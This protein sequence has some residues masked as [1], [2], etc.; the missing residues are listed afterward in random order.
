MAEMK[1]TSSSV[2]VEKQEPTFELSGKLAA[3]TNRYAGVNLLY[4]QPPEARN[5][6]EKWRLYIF[7][8]GELLDVEPIPVHASFKRLPIWEGSK[9]CRR[10]YGPS[11]QQQATRRSSV[12]AGG[13]GET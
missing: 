7:K 12:S 9:G 1:E 2:G 10:S 6:K 11:V 13:A 3:E 8:S 5:P 4:S